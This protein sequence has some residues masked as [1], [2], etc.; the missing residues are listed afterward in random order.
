[1]KA[2]FNL[3]TSL[4]VRFRIVTLALVGIVIVLGIIAAT[5]LK[6]ELLPPI[7]FPQTIILAQVSGLTSEQVMNVLTEPLEAKLDQI[8]EL[9]NIESTT[10]G[11]FGSGIQT[12]NE[13]GLD[14]DRLRERI[15]AA[16]DEVWLP[17]RRLQPGDGEDPQAFA[18][19]LLADL[20][21]DVLIFLA[22]RD[23]NF[24]FQL[25]PEVWASF[26]AETQRAAL[27]YLAGQVEASEGEKSALRHL[28]DQEIVPKLDVL[29]EVATINVSGG[30]A[31]PGEGNGA[32]APAAVQT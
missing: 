31:L 20:T 4:S 6:Q 23:P 17:L 25:A 9:V 8:N 1:M 3:L 16:I 10:T 27:A 32:S 29:E 12:S 28:V 24:L 14:Q 30:Q 7:E 26:P 18:D 5:Q 2:F 22:E 11:A 19:R 21:P 13:F 15:R